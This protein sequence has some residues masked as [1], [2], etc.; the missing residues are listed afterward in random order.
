[1]QE[2]KIRK[3]MFELLN[4]SDAYL[5]L[6]PKWRSHVESR[7]GMKKPTGAGPVRHH[8]VVSCVKRQSAVPSLSS[9]KV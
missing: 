7:Q 9:K 1:M 8:C 6:F 3:L 2:L 5:F 4:L